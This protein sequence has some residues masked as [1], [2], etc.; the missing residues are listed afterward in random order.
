MMMMMTMMMMMMSFGTS[1][2]DASTR[3]TTLYGSN[4]ASNGDASRVTFVGVLF[5]QE[6]HSRRGPFPARVLCDHHIVCGRKIQIYIRI[7]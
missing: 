5:S 4:H 7:H 1:L 2:N 3:A 6:T